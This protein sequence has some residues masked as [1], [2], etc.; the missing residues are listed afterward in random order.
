MDQ[1]NAHQLNSGGGNY[2]TWE[3]CGRVNKLS[4]IMVDGEQ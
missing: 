3:E 2:G 1:E 4:G